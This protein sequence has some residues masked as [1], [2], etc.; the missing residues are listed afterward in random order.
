MTKTWKYNFCAAFLAWLLSGCARS[1]ASSPEDKA[2]T[3]GRIKW[4]AYD[5]VA[6]GL[7]NN[8]VH[9][10]TLQVSD[11][12]IRLLGRKMCD[13]RIELGD[14]FS[15]SLADSIDSENVSH[16]STDGRETDDDGYV[17][18]QD[19]GARPDGQKNDYHGGFGLTGDRDDVPTFSWDWFVVDR[20]G[21]ATKLQESGKLSFDM[22]KT[23]TGT[24]IHHM[25]FLTDVSIRVDRQSDSSALSPAWRIKIFKGS[26]ISWPAS[27]GST[28]RK[29][30]GK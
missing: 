25:V 4:A 29:D 12:K 19:S 6:S 30:S 11:V 15:F 7:L 9:E 10:K 13:K 28:V 1:V 20:P 14:H 5:T 26:S 2:A 3:I 16:K 24:E 23:S 27:E 17:I 21:H 8:G 18:T 22:M